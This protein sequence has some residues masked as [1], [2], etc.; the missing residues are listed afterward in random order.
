GGP[1]IIEKVVID[2]STLGSRPGYSSKFLGDGK[3]EAP[4]P[5][6]PA[7]LK[8]DV[9]PLLKKPG[10]YLLKYYNYSV[11]MNKR[12]KFAFFAAVNIDGKLRRDV[13]KR[14][15][16]TWYRDPR[17]DKDYQIG[18]E[19]Y[20]KQALDE[21]RT[22][23]PFDR[24]HLV[25]RLDATWGS[26][27]ALAKRNGNDTFHFTNC[28]PQFF[29]FNQG[30]KM[31]LGLEE[32]VLDQ[33]E[34]D[35]RRACVMNGPVFDGPEADE[36]E[37]PDP[38]A[39]TK[40][41]PKFKGVAIPKFFWKLMVIE[42]S[43]VLA[44]AAFLLSQQDLIFGIDRIEEKLTPAEAKMYQ[45][46]IADLVKFTKL[47]FGKLAQSDTKEATRRAKPRLIENLED[48]RF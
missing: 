47:N 42:Q 35:K 29:K 40:A 39:P 36:G 25:R 31:W 23:N 12:R 9:A 48:I 22:K 16:D 43:G 13:G 1:A 26:S 37:M 19:F 2:Q 34:A 17:I 41:D 14:E 8:K 33:L 3:L 38:D 20:A 5:T 30:A 18:D 21:A 32:Y 10:E 46:S 44:A 45:V 15:G 6:L 11:A 27:E 24:G 28:T 7:S 4:L